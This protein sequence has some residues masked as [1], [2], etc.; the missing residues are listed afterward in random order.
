VLATETGMNVCDAS[1]WNTVLNWLDARGSGYLAWAW[2]TTREFD[3][4]SNISERREH[5][6][7]GA[8]VRDGRQS[9][10]VTLALRDR[11][12]NVATG[13]RGRVHRRRGLAF[14]LGD[15]LDAAEP[16]PHG[17]GHRKLDSHRDPVHIGQSAAAGVMTC[18]RSG[19]CHVSP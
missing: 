13:Y 1:F 18:P 15:A 16:D 17:Q 19:P 8:G 2:T 14:V 12:G 11:F 6:P 5:E 9:F 3:C 10:T 7:R 4:A